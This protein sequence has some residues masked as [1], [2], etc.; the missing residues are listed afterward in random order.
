MRKILCAVLF[1]L[2]LV[3]SALLGSDQIGQTSVRPKLEK[4]SLDDR[5]A[6]SLFF[7]GMIRLDVCGYTIFGDKPVSVTGYWTSPD[8]ATD[9][10]SKEVLFKKGQILWEKHKH[11]FP[12][13]NFAITF[14][15]CQDWCGLQII[16][17]KAFKQVVSQYI[18]EFKKVLG[19]GIT[20]EKLLER[21]SCS[22]CDISEVLKSDECLLGIVLGY[23]Y[24]NARAY[25][26]KNEIAASLKKHF[27]L[28]DNQYVC[29]G[30]FP[31]NS[32][33]VPENIAKLLDEY[34]ALDQKLKYSCG[35]SNMLELFPDVGFRADLNDPETIALLKSYAQT[36][37]KIKNAFLSDNFLEAVLCAMS[38]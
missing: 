38:E 16:N 8:S 5:E 3:S 7:E 37:P 14:V 26:Q 9:V 18:E 1:T 17:K 13:P 34:K 11:L 32:E 20:A 36:K 2:G 19:P 23:G 21:V 30:M 12:M 15:T 22:N 25:K 24:K 28:T 4:M 27:G 29:D 31:E 10:F 35:D 33:N 6:L